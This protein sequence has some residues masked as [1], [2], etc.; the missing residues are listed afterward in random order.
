MKMYRTILTI[1]CLWFAVAAPA[2]TVYKWVDQNG[3]V[4]YTTTPP[5]NARSKVA[6]V[7]VAPA[8]RG[9]APVQDNA[10]AQYWRARTERE[11]ASEMALERQRRDTESLRQAG[12]HQQLAA[13]E[14][15]ARKKTAV[16]AAYEQCRAER[17]VDCDANTGIAAGKGYA[18]GMTYPLVAYPQV[19]IV[20]RPAVRPV[21]PVPYFSSPPTFTPGF[22]GMMTP[23]R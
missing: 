7:D 22:S 18:V 12:L 4:N 23:R 2:S 6:T 9:I 3:V 19:V 10:E 11:V 14:N 20:A 17:R 1:G 13:A 16:Q 15:E 5:S 21:S 8:V